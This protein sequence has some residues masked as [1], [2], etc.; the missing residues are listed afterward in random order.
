MPEVW[1][2]VSATKKV[3]R[4]ESTIEWGGTEHACSG[5]GKRGLLT[6]RQGKMLLEKHVEKYF[7]CGCK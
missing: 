2:V 1:S 4:E 3:K 7:P 5:G 6:L